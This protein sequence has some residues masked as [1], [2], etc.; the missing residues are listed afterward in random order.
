MILSCNSC[1]K[2]LW[3]QIRLFSWEIVQYGSCGNKWKQFSVNIEIKKPQT[4]KKPKNIKIS[5]E[6]KY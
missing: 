6:T 5:S 2:N 1:E 4:A 3:F